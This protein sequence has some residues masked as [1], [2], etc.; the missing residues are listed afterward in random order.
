[1]IRIKIKDLPRNTK[2]GHEEWRMVH[3]GFVPIFLNLA[4]ISAEYTYS[5]HI[6]E[7]GTT[8][9]QF[10]DGISGSRPPSGSAN[11]SAAYGAN[12]SEE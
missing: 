8:T 1:V 12:D 3:G 5:I 2:I 10:G 11:I 6:D 4:P 7:G 9:I